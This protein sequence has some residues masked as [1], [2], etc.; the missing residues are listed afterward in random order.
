MKRSLGGVILRIV[1]GI[2]VVAGSFF[3]TLFL[4]DRFDQPAAPGIVTVA[5]AS[6]GPACRAKPGNVTGYVAQ[7]CDQKRKCSLTIDAAKMGDPAPGC[8]KDF[9]VKYRCQQ[10]AALHNI[11][12][13]AEANGKTVD[14]DC[15]KG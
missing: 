10:N 4:V 12:I 15:E 7:A 1:G 5:E 3:I 8:G 13:A 6:Y 14:L 2:A 9:S 11:S